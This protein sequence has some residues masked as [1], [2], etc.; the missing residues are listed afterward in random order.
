[1]VERIMSDIKLTLKDNEKIA[2]ISDIHMDSV[3]P[4][5]RIDDILE[6]ACVKL[7][8][9]YDKCVERNVKA[10]FCEGDIL[11]RISEPY[12]V[13]NLLGNILNKF[14]DAGIKVYSICGNHDILRNNLENIERSPIQTLFTFGVMTHI[15]LSNR[16]I[17]ND[18]MLI[19]PV[20]YTEFPVKADKT[21]R[22]NVLLAHMFFNANKFMSDDKHNITSKNLKEWGYDVVILGHDHTEYPTIID[23]GTIVVRHGSLIRGT[24]HS[25]NFNRHPNFLVFNDLNNI[26]LDTI[27]KVVVEHKP[28]KDVV[29]N[30][31][32]NKKNEGTISGLQDV[33]SNL[34]D[35][36]TMSSEEDSDRILDIIKSD[37]KL[38][39][40]VRLQI[41]QYINQ[42]CS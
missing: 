25:Y 37:E 22:T 29:S 20:D 33:L 19:T 36:L 30:Y 39:N 32:L 41:L 28:Y 1:M 27:E 34:A 38:P 11:N 40:E 5:S 4:N 26:T 17:I 35:K 23:E 6:T 24:A 42:Y 18:S 9:I 10:V 13:I 7:N 14:R 31:V 16:V 12:I 2:F 3:T 21:Y 15:N 8:D